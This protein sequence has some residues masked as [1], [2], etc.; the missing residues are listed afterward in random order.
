M[1]RWYV[2]LIILSFALGSAIF[3]GG[4][5]L[6]DH[7]NKDK[8]DRIRQAAFASVSDRLV[9]MGLPRD[10]LQQVSKGQLGRTDYF[11]HILVAF[12]YVNRSQ[13]LAFSARC[14]EVDN[15][16]NCHSVEWYP[17]HEH[18]EKCPLS[19]DME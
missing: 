16:A 13:C 11:G 9:E 1:R 18:Q 19:L 6:N 17:Y 3:F 8:N 7:E 4:A 12:F 14:Y 15:V 5:T 10:G 2:H